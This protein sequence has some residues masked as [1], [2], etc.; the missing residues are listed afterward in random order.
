MTFKFFKDQTKLYIQSYKFLQLLGRYFCYNTVRHDHESSLTKCTA[1]PARIC[2]NFFLSHQPVTTHA[3]QRQE[4]F[5]LLALY[6]FTVSHK[7][8]ELTRSRDRRWPGRGPSFSL[9]TAH[10]AR[11]LVLPLPPQH[12]DPGIVTLPLFVWLC[13]DWPSQARVNVRVS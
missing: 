3:T 1:W 13:T 6:Q 7:S 5:L 2:P 8:S 4:F 9:P 10:C 11:K 12:S